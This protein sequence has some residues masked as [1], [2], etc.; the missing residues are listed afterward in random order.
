MRPQARPVVAESSNCCVD[1]ASLNPRDEG[2][3]VR[4]IGEPGPRTSP[5]RCQSSLEQSG[6]FYPWP[7][8]FLP[9]RH[10]FLKG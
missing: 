9:R 5:V 3:E 7:S 8:P 2:F 1:A 4:F 10:N 6:L